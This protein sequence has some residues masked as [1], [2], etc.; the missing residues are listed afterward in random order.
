MREAIQK[1]KYVVRHADP[2]Y[3]EALLGIIN[4]FYST[5]RIKQGIDQKSSHGVLVPLPKCSQKDK[6][7][8]KSNRF[9]A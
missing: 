7:D 9:T 3:A 5:L 4:D 1:L 6:G 2:E 8:D